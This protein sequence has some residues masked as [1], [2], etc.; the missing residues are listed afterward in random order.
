MVKILTTVN[1]KCDQC[2]IIQTRESL[3][4]F[5][6]EGWIQVDGKDYQPATLEFCSIECYDTF[7]RS[8]NVQE[9]LKE[10]KSQNGGVWTWSD[11][12]HYKISINPSDAV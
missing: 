5:Y 7:K 4:D 2:K 10:R 12:K 1:I 8:F 11:K 9:K 3:D 6:K